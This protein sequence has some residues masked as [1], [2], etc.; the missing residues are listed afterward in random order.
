[1]PKVRIEQ[2]KQLVLAAKQQFQREHLLLMEELPKLYNSRVDYIKPCVNSLL[3]SQA[4]FYEA[5]TCYYDSI[6]SSTSELVSSRVVSGSG[7][8]G[9][10]GSE[11]ASSTEL[12]D[13]EIQKCLSEIKSLSIVAGD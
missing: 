9:A 5:Y 8:G 2:Q 1:M 3:Q 6:L 7:G 13:E 4:N 12:V 10:E 11:A